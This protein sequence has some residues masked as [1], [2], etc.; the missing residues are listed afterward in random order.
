MDH[1][2]ELVVQV[3]RHDFNVAFNAA[4][5]GSSGPGLFVYLRGNAELGESPVMG[6]APIEVLNV[7]S[8]ELFAVGVDQSFEVCACL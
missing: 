8:G 1:S 7:I 2:L 5:N 3:L 6:E 4:N